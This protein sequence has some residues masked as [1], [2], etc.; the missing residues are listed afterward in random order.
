MKKNYWLLMVLLLTV[1][2]LKVQAFPVTLKIIDET[3]GERT[4]NVND[5]NEVNVFAWLSDSFNKGS[6][7]EWW[8]PF[9]A[10]SG[11]TG[12]LIKN[13]GDWTWQASFD[14]AE[15]TY[16]WNP[17]MKTLGWKPMNKAV[18]YYGDSNDLSFTVSSTGEIEGVTEITIS[19]V[20]TTLTLKVM[21]KSKGV[22]TNAPANDEANLFF[23][24]GNPEGASTNLYWEFIAPASGWTD[25]TYRFFPPQGNQIEKTEDAWIWSADIQVRT[26]CYTWRPQAISTGGTVNNSIYKY[27]EN[28]DGGFLQ[29]NVDLNG[30]VSGITQLEIPD[31]V[32]TS[33]E[34]TEDAKVKFT[35]ERGILQISGVYDSVKIYTS[36]GILISNKPASSYSLHQGLYIVI[37]DNISHKILIY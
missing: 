25:W 8:Y 24:G 13:A 28:P 2:F 19:N 17:H 35:V 4:N 14:L 29:F 27:D 23:D 32:P 34:K 21:D 15:G 9:Y 36:N 6:W 1:C 20:P 30:N 18:L 11:S 7:T 5:N 37:V 3:M 26:G 31:P 16:E 12:E 33:I 22:L 10:E